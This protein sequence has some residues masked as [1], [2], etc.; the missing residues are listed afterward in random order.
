M[1]EKRLNIRC[2]SDS[3]YELW[4]EAAGIDKR[5]VSDWARIQLDEAASR[6]LH[7]QSTK[8]KK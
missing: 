4:A 2:T 3:Q 1:S 6:Q 7:E 5:K 8:K